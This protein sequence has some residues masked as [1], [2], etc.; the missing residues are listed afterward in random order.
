V[1]GS[2]LTEAYPSRKAGS[3]KTNLG[4]NPGNLPLDRVRVDSSE[5]TLTTNLGVPVGDNQNSLKAGHAK[6]R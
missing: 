5:R 6:G 4:H 3:G 2:T 1:T